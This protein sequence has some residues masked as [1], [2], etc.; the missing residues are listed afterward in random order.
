MFGWLKSDPIEKLDKQYRAK[1][2]E[3]MQAQ[4]NGD[5]RLYAQLT[6]EAEVILGEL[7]EAKRK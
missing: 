5:M 3:A 4:R 2:Q 7:N 1:L 6:E